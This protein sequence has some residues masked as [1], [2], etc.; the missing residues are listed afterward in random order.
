MRPAR[1]QLNEYFVAESFFR[2]QVGY[3]ESELEENFRLT[4]SH[5][6]I[7]VSLGEH[8]ENPHN[9]LCQLSVSLEDETEE[10]FPFVFKI[11]LL[12]FFDIDDNCSPEEAELLLKT[13]APSVLY[14]AAREFLLLTTGRSMFPPVMLPTVTFLP[15]KEE[16]TVKKPK[17]LA[18]KPAAKPKLKKPK[19]D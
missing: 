4:P 2:A 10:A 14:S 15:K 17:Q 19:K 11:V 5:L 9:H 12:G 16:K 8:A 13:N 6:K 18:K 3:A 7:E 1:M